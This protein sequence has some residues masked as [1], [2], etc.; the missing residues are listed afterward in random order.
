MTH[1]NLFKIIVGFFLISLVG[2]SFSAPKTDYGNIDFEATGSKEAHAVFTK[3]LLQL[4][5][6]EYGDARENFLKAQAIDPDFVMAYWGEALSYENP[7]WH[8]YVTDKSR[9][10]LAK[11]GATSKEQISKAKTKRER[12]YIRSITILFDEG[13]QQQRELN[14]REAMESIHR[15]YP[16]DMDAA[17]LHAL[18]IL[19]TSH[20]GRD[21]S[22]YMQAGAITEEILDK[23]PR[24]PGA[25][26]YNIH[27]F[28][29]PIHAPLGL[30][31]ANIYAEVAP[32]AVHALHMGAHIYFALGMWDKGTERNLRSFEE[33][34]A[35]HERPNGEIGMQG[36]HA[37]T[38]LIYSYLQEGNYK[39]AE[40]KTAAIHDQSKRFKMSMHRGNFIVARAAYLI[41][42][43][44]LDHAF[45]DIEIDHKDLGKYFTA[46]DDYVRGIVALHK[47]NIN[48][49]KAA[50][51]DMDAAEAI[52]SRVRREAAPHLLHLSLSGQI[53]LAEGNTKQALALIEESARL[54][55]GLS[56]DYGP[57]VPAKPSSEL[58]AET[59][60]AVGDVD[61]AISQYQAT[62]KS[63]VNRARSV[64]GLRAATEK[65]Q[66]VTLK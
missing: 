38:W 51:K 41:D 56:P 60:L 37:L 7:L 11:L 48:N 49:A 25:L 47:G 19:T 57:A 43:G 52:A 64:E 50:L 59:Y 12:E 3:G 39:A 8:R 32:S 6:F 29:D 34:V 36:Y 46:T 63:Y 1:S 5:N 15:N 21:F 42:S 54:E 20:G 35:R 9:A 16:E 14:Y 65:L 44:D 2:T 17:A 62:L 61:R 26:H 58:L 33:S 40:E 66:K 55:A 4:H 30:R 27:S 18:S 45:A 31:A 28:D 24:H 23:N 53:A 13:T 22:L 10:A